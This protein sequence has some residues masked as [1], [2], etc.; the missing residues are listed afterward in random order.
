MLHELG[1][2]LTEE[3]EGRVGDD[4]IRLF[5]Q[6]DALG[7]A[8]VAAG[9]L[10]VAFQRSPGGLVALEK[11]RNVGHVRRAVAVLVLHTVEGDGERLWLTALAIPLAVFRE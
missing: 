9:I 3:G 1:D 7:A 5:Q 8:E 10:V 4:D 2:V 6:R 11:K